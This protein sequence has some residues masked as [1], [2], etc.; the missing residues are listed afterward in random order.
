MKHS[1]SPSSHKVR[2][3]T[4]VGIGL[5]LLGVFM[6]AMNDV[7]GKWLVA[8]Y[9]VGQVL[10]LRSV[11]ALMILLPLMRRQKVPFAIPPQPGLHAVRIIL[12]TL[13]VAC[14]YWAVTYLPLADVMTYY[15]A[16]PIYVAAFAAFW[17]GEKIDKPR[18]LAIGIGFVGVLI[19]LRPSTAT[20][21]LPA[22]IALAGSLFYSLLMI[23]TR[24]LRETHDATLVL[25][26]ILGALIFGLIAAP[27]AWVTPGPLD[28]A[29]LFLLGIVSM[30][31]HVCVN[32]S[33]K[34]APASVVAPYQYTLI[35]WAI[36]LGYLFFGD[37]VQ[38]WTLVGAAVICGAGLAL[39][40]LEREA[41]R[42][43]REAKDIE[44]P[45]LPEA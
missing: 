5:M 18:I 25:G 23:T 39:L 41:A 8:T 43:G 17:L 16:G 38:F 42:R 20:L 4:L 2:S 44:T 21:S 29:G 7:M 3:G 22:L 45:V 40:L 32:R 36:V 12:S 33:L 27:L 37:V 34:I 28:L 6:F 19:A 1:S 11:A 14:F 15:L 26:Q 9:S 13:E 35:V 31:A 24:K 10:L 30:V